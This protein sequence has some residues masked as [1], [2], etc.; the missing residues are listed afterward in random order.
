[1]FLFGLIVGLVIG[2]VIAILVYHN[3]QKKFN[4]YIDETEVELQ[5]VEAK[6]NAKIKELEAKIE[7]LLAPKAIP[8]PDQKS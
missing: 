1:M 7:N 8:V 3:N 6:A 4:D 5:T 2:A